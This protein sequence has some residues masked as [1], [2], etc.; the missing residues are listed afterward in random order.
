MQTISTAPEG[1]YNLKQMPAGQMPG[2]Q[3]EENES[4]INV[5][6][7]NRFTLFDQDEQ[8]ARSVIQQKTISTEKTV[9]RLGVM[10][11]GLGGNNGST[12]TAGILAN[13]RQL[14]WQTRNGEQKAN[15]YG[16]FTQSAT[17]HC[18]FRFDEETGQLK[19]VHKPIKELL[20]MANPVDFE[21]SGWDINNSNLYE[22]ALRSRVLEPTLIE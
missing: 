14:T 15:F 6:Y 17:T 9:P 13:K 2:I 22:A 11:V 1:T 19:D 21:V 16:S 18:G 7:E 20:P 3:R 12:F 5:T 10:L 4:S 8:A